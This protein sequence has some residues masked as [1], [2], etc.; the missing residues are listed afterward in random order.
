[1]R[2]RLLALWSVPRA[3]STAFLR[4]IAE[5]GDL[6]VVHEP[7]SRVRGMGSVAVGGRTCRSATEVM[8]ALQLLTAEGPVFFK[9]T[10][11]KRYPDVLADL[12]FQRAATH[13]FM[14][15]SPE[16]VVASYLRISAGAERD[17][18]GFTNLLELHDA[19]CASTRQEAFV[20]DGDQLVADPGRTVE[21]YCRH[22][23]IPF[24]AGA[25]QWE[26]GAL[27]G[28]NDFAHWHEKAATTT[29]FVPTRPEPLPVELRGVA[30]RFVA[31]HQPFY[32]QLLARIRTPGADG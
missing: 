1:M 20:V 7:F 29:G 25:L 16:A 4:M 5:R 8:Q 18:M 27:D 17:E 6:T 9:D 21:A 14:I 24:R 26:A 30:E 22:V 3:R 12:D 13:S 10:M 28:W 31:Y 2:R 32:D 23:G 15:R 11:D 19:V